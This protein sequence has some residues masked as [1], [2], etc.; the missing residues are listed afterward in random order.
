MEAVINGGAGNPEQAPSPLPLSVVLIW[1]AA[2][3]GLG[4]YVASFWF[5]Q[6]AQ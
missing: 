1:V 3:A 5:P 4:A 2:F 6:L